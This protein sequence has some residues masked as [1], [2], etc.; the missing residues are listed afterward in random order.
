LGLHTQVIVF[1]SC[2]PLCV[3]V[4][5]YIFYRR[6]FP[7]RRSML[8]MGLILVGTVIYV[9]VD[10]DLSSPSAAKA[11]LWVCVWFFLLIFQLTYAK[12]LVSGLG[13]NSIW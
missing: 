2:A 8:A 7:S 3:S 10:K 13:L 6:A 5:D 4:M 11:Y 1:R 12:T 9:A